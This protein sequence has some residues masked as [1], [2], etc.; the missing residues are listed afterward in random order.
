MSHH[1]FI[2]RLPERP[3][4]TA[5]QKGV[6]SIGG[7]VRFYTKAS[8]A[9]TRAMY[10][11]GIRQ[12]FLRSG[13]PIPFLE[14]AIYARIQFY[15]AV[16]DER[17][18]GQYKPTVPDCDNLVKLLLDVLTELHFWRDDAQIAVLEV[19]KFYGKENLFEIELED[20]L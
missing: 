19:E 15:F 7:R 14:G 11:T 5:Q 12:E 2:V 13:R 4:G 18:W 1:K 17:L 8:V 16:K 9:K 6:S 10:I 3:T 20:K